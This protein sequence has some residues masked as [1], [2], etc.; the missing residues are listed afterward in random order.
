MEFKYRDGDNKTPTALTPTPPSY[1]LST[2]AY[3]S[4]RALQGGFSGNVPAPTFFRLPAPGFAN[5]ALRHELE[6]E[7]RR[8]LE[9]EQ[10]RREIIAGEIAQRRE[11]EEEVRR[12]MA[13]ERQLQGIPV[14]RSVGMAPER[15]C[16]DWEKQFCSFVFCSFRLV[17]CQR[18]KP[19]PNR[20]KAETPVVSF[21]SQKKPRE[22]WSCALCQISATSE[23][24]LKDHL[25]GRKHKAKQ[26]ASTTPQIGLDDRVD[27]ESPQPSVTTTNMNHSMVDD[28]T[29]Q[30][31]GAEQLQK[32][33][34][35]ANELATGKDAEKKN[36]PRRGKFK[37]W[38]EICS[39]G[40]RSGTV[41]ESH[42]KGKKH[43]KRCRENNEVYPPTTSSVSLESLV[44]ESKGVIE[45]ERP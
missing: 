36:E 32:S 12:E 26:A 18:A 34:E 8:E 25:Q 41:M 22:E 42:K 29:M 4:E 16:T 15:I 45:G 28:V 35:N 27:I 14:Q 31:K 9:K 20:R 38:C 23:Q 13:M 40:T 7:V 24:G 1:S 2:L 10:I 21:G 3:V 11:L 37:F 44:D 17:C 6:R 5:Q 19:S 39:V 30:S 33:V 43:M